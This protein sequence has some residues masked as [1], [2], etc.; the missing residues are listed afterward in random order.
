MIA[1]VDSSVLMRVVMQQPDRLT[2]L[3][4]FDERVTSRLSQ[5]ECLRTL[6][7][8]RL[9]DGLEPDDVVQRAAF[10]HRLLRQM[11]RV[12]VSRAVLDRAGEA[13]P[14]PVQTLDAIHLATAL[15]LRDR[16][17]ADLVFATHD[18]TQGRTALA[19]GFEVI[20]L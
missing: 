9:V 16:A 10:V 17:R 5:A 2:G 6:D 7:K 15:Q 19:L 13:F 11:S 3:T 12:A 14:L 20:G 18:L 8:A 4:S 1:Y